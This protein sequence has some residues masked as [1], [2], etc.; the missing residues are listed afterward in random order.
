MFGGVVSDDARGDILA[1]DTDPMRR[2][3]TRRWLVLATLAAV[4]CG[5]VGS[6]LRPTWVRW[7]SFRD[8][9]RVAVSDSGT[10]IAIFDQSNARGS[11]A[12][13][14]HPPPANGTLMILDDAGD[15]LAERTA[16]GGEL[17]D[18]AI[19]DRGNAYLLRRDVNELASPDAPL[20]PAQLLAVAP[21]GS[22]RWSVTPFEDAGI[23]PVGRVLVLPEHV[24]VQSGASIAAYASDGAPAWSTTLDVGDWGSTLHRGSLWFVG[25]TDDAER[26]TVAVRCDPRGQ[27][28]APIDLGAARGRVEGFDVADESI[29]VRSCS[30]DS[31]DEV[32]RITRYGFDGVASWH[33]AVDSSQHAMMLGDTVW[34]IQSPVTH[35]ADATGAAT[36][37]RRHMVLRRHGRDGAVD[38]AWAR[39]FVEDEEDAID[40]IACSAELPSAGAQV[41]TLSSLADGRLLLAGSQGCTD[42]FI[43]ALEVVR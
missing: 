10:R 5:D 42:A 15:V 25:A 28:D 26:R 1:R 9:S 40:R 33:H 31:A 24:A 12:L 37:E 23:Q 13:L 19:D 30:D 16:L 17:A 43:L 7:R 32:C 4:T 22:D 21:D 27:C 34:S 20:V 8:H 41:R 6:T 3:V 11:T 36:R 14:A 35:D 39:T 29:L 38:L 2:F 18:V